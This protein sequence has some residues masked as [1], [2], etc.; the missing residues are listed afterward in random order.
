LHDVFPARTR[1]R[2]FGWL[3]GQTGNSFELAVGI[4]PRRRAPQIV[5]P[6]RWRPF[7]AR[8]ESSQCQQFLIRSNPTVSDSIRP[9]PKASVGIGDPR[10]VIFGLKISNSRLTPAN[11]FLTPLVLPSYSAA[12]NS[13]GSFAGCCFDRLL[14]RKTAS[15]DIPDAGAQVIPAAIRWCLV[16]ARFCLVL[17]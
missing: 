1:L 7:V 16:G 9:N 11:S 5:L 12:G 17:L 2:G 13:A 14:V 3:V 8:E 10:L 15:S 4:I 6:W